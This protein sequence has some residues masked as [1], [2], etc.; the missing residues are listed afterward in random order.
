MQLYP[1]VTKVAKY[2]PDN[3]VTNDDLAEVMDTS[4]E[5]ISSRTGIRERRISIKETTSD[6]AT[7][8]AKQLIQDLDVL[9]IDFI[10]VATMTADYA[11]PSTACLVQSNI[12]ASNAFCLDINAACSGFVFAMSTA[13][14]FLSS[15][16]YKRG[17]VIGAETMSTMLNW[18]DRGTAVLFGDGAAGVLLEN[19]AKEKRFIDEL[20]QSDGNRSMALFGKENVDGNPFKAADHRVSTGM[21]MD[22]KKIFDFALRDVSKN[23]MTLLDRNEEFKDSLDYVLAHQANIRILEAISKKTKLPMASFLHN[24]SNYG[25]T[26][27]ASVPLLLAEKVEDGTLR[28]Q[29]NQKIML[30]GYGAGL[31]WGSILIKL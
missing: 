24:V 13:E 8:V 19:T 9:S 3:I 23:M 25:N 17:L 12:G 27:A 15:G 10:L 14:K 16:H 21:Q 28:L 22:G 1:Q 30:T 2:L 20:I 26:S 4:D 31:T 7:E 6:L 18:E 5:W 29:S 11:T